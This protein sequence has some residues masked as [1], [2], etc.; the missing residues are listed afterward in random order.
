[1]QNLKEISKQFKLGTP[2]Y[3]IDNGVIHTDVVVAQHKFQYAVEDSSALKN[4]VYI[5]DTNCIVKETILVVLAYSHRIYTT[6]KVYIPVDIKSQHKVRSIY[7][8]YTSKEGLLES[9]R[10]D[11]TING[12]TLTQTPV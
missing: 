8:L 2:V 4:G 9:I 7:K 5:G 3:Y 11:V 6:D 1:M 10:L 12:N